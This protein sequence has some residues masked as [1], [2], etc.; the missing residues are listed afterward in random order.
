MSEGLERVYGVA[1][2]LSRATDLVLGRFE[3]VERVDDRPEVAA[4][5]SSFGRFLLCS[6]GVC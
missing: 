6:T 3:G 2:A 1:L 5:E 4:K